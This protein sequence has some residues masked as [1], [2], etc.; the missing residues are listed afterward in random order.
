MSADL[1]KRLYEMEV[2]PPSPVW[3]K[4]SACLDEINADNLISG[5]IYNA[6]QPPDTGAW[7]KIEKLIHPDL[8]IIPAKKLPLINLKRLA[9][10]AV[11]SII[12]ISA[13]LLIKNLT[14]DNLIT[15]SLPLNELAGTDKDR[16]IPGN[17]F[18]VENSLHSNV[19]TGAGKQVKYSLAMLTDQN[20][21]S[22]NQKKNFRLPLTQIK[23]ELPGK[24][25]NP[26][27]KTFK[28]LIDDLSMATE[29]SRYMTMVNENGRLVKI[30][31][32]LA[33]LAPHLQGKPLSEDYYEVLFGEGAYWQETLQD[34]RKKLITS[35][36]ASGDSF[37][38]F[39]ELLKTVS[40]R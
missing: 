7:N 21:V 14:A 32:H 18:S 37:T 6:E 23:N 28:A 17:N 26:E 25:K 9:V 5:K 31:T 10:A 1:N 24:R 8:E 36:I 12:V 35:P 16:D 27:E 11:V 34:W 4:I 15:D 13:W 22:R 20:A 2:N 29:G 19:A 3:E 33:H 30:P 40:N 39:I 38:S